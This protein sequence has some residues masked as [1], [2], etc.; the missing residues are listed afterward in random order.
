MSF[1]LSSLKAKSDA[2]PVTILHPETGEELFD[3]KGSP[4]QLHVYGKASKKYRDLTDAR[5]KDAIAQGKSSGKNKAPELTV[6][7]VRKDSVEWAVS[8]TAK[9]T[10][11]VDDEGNP[12]DNSDAIRSIYENPEYFWLLEQ[13]NAA[14]ENDSNFF[15]P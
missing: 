10:G 2:V 14:I 9:I 1:K 11:M 6:D 13:A 3:D 4:I 15:K 7:K 12:F 5:L 8:L